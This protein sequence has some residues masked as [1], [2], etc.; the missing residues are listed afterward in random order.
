MLGKGIVDLQKNEFWCPICR[1]LANALLPIVNV[2]SFQRMQH[3]QK[4]GGTKDTFNLG[5]LWN[6][7]TNL[8][9]TIDNFV[10][11][12]YSTFKKLNQIVWVINNNSGSI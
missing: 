3:V 5:E 4:E 2:L 6:P 11:Q 1:R 8:S 12:V 10:A 7:Q 9:T